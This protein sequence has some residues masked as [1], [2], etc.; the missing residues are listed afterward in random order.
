MNQTDIDSDDAADTPDWEFGMEEKAALTPRKPRKTHALPPGL[1]FSFTEEEMESHLLAVNKLHKDL[2]ASMSTIEPGQARF[3]VDLYYQLQKFRI[4]LGGQIR[5]Q[6]RAGEATLVLEWFQAQFM[7][8][9]NQAKNALRKYAKSNAAGQWALAIDGIGPVITAGLLA[10][11]QIDRHNVDPKK[12]MDN[13]S[14]LQR[15]AGMDP[16]VSWDKGEKRPWNAKLKTLCYKFGESFVKLQGKEGAFYPPMFR[17]FKQEELRRNDDGDYAERAWAARDK[18]DKTTDAW[19]W[20]NG[21]YPSG[22][23]SLLQNIADSAPD[24]IK[25][26]KKK[27]AEWA[28]DERVRLLKSERLD[29]GEGLPML[30]PSQIHARAR[31]RVAKI[32]LVHFWEESWI[33]KYNEEPAAPWVFV[34]GG[35]ST[36]IYRPNPSQ[37]TNVPP[38]V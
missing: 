27:V 8:L 32:F 31:R 12:R 38:R 11:I 33:A 29:P 14:K 1:A 9:E 22:M 16:T 24:A 17:E 36:R 2:L 21:C 6:E 34:H 19:K 15:F 3:L 37:V 20:V 7:I 4:T 30:P 10:H 35:H 5:S 28:A 23:C 18:Y 13:P 25:G 26:N